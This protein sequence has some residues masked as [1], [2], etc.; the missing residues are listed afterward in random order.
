MASPR[1]RQAEAPSLGFSR[2]VKKH[3]DG[4]GLVDAVSTLSKSLSQE[5]PGSPLYKIGS[6]ENQACGHL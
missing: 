2:G 5:A 6:V 1:R 3:A 4:Q